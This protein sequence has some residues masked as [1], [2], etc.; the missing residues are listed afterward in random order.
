MKQEREKNRK[1]QTTCLLCLLPRLKLT[2]DHPQEHAAFLDFK[3]KKKKKRGQI[4]VFLFFLL[5]ASLHRPFRTNGKQ[6]D[7]NSS[8]RL[9]FIKPAP[10]AGDQT[11]HTHSQT[12]HTLTSL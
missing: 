8:L 12:E 3:K 4:V 11:S 6:V 2:S 9:L 5:V 1:R 10:K 7:N